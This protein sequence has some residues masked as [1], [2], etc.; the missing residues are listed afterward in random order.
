MRIYARKDDA[1]VGW[2]FSYELATTKVIFLAFFLTPNK[3][4]IDTASSSD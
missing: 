1:I 4:F 3:C 2:A